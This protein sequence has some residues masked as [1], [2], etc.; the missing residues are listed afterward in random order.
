MRSV[1]RLLKRS[2]FVFAI[3]ELMA[4]DYSYDFWMIPVKSIDDA[5]NAGRMNF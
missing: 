2:S 3:S 4:K 1:D 5:V